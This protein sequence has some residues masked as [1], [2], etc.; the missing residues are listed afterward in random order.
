VTAWLGWYGRPVFNETGVVRGNVRF[1]KLGEGDATAIV[2]AAGI[3]DLGDEVIDTDAAICDHRLNLDR[4]LAAKSCKT[5][6]RP[7]TT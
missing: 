6:A 5:P 1:P 3:D 4:A 7:A 2:S